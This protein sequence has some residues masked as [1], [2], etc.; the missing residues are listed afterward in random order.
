MLA[1]RI[2]DD[3]IRQTDVGGMFEYFDPLTGKGLGGKIFHGLLQSFLNFIK[4]IMISGY[5]IINEIN[6]GIYYT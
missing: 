1:K 4:K 3:T 5:L 2:K 6:N